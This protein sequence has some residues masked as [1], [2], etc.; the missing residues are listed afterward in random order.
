MDEDRRRWVLDGVV[1]PMGLAEVARRWL[2]NLAARG[3]LKPPTG[4]LG[5][6]FKV[7]H[8][9]F[10]LGPQFGVLSAVEHSDGGLG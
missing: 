10:G 1:G 2:P 9:F 6:V 4:H 3:A 8:S 7:T 5:R